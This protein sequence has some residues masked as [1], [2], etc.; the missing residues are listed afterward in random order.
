MKP[1]N[2]KTALKFAAL[3]KQRPVFLWGA[4]GVGK[5]EVVSQIAKEL[6]ITLI[7][8]RLAQSDPTELKGYPWPNQETKTMVFFRDNELPTKGKGI[9]FLDEMNSAPQA[10]QAAAYQLILDRRIGDYELPKGWIIIAAGNRSGDRS[11]VHSMPAALANRFVHLDFEPDAEDWVDWAAANKISDVIRGYIR[12]RPNNLFTDK[13]EPG[14]RA[15]PTPRTWVFAD[16]IINSNL[17]PA[18]ELELLKGTIGEGCAIEL[19]GF[20]RDYKLLPSIDRIMLS[21]ET[22]EVP[23]KPSVGHAVVAA[24]ETR[25]T[26]SNMASVFKYIKRLEIAEFQTVFMQSMAKRGDEYCETEVMIQW[27]RENRAALS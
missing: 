27:I 16:Q 15:F 17:A 12:Y 23:K 5:S 7:D 22:A 25:T 14:M 11:V 20:I 21:P 9:L 24:L 1:S 13:I 4:P 6:K 8:K 2:I 19:S 10:V 18:I 3:D 26:P